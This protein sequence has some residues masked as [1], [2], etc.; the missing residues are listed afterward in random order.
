MLF[1]TVQQV[2]SE[3][4]VALHEILRI[5]RTIHTCQIEHKVRL[6]AVLVQLRRRRIQ[7]VLEDFFN[8]QCRTGLVFPIP[9]VFQVVY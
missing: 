9:D 5:L 7:I 4:E 3:A 8:V 1:Q 6:A 2:R